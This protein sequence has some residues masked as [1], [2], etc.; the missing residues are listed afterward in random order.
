MELSP[1]KIS[2]QIKGLPSR[3]E[4]HQNGRPWIGEAAFYELRPRARE[5]STLGKV[6]FFGSF[7]QHTKNEQTICQAQN[8]FH[9]KGFGLI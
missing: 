3:D 9:L 1:G 6:P 2:I 7:F 4:K 8:I 5:Q